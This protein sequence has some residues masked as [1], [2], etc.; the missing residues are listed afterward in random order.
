[1]NF[2]V[3]LMPYYA[4]TY[5]QVIKCLGGGKVLLLKSPFGRVKNLIFRTRIVNH[6]MGPTASQFRWMTW[7]GRTTT[8]W[9]ST[10]WRDVLRREAGFERQTYRSTSAT[11]AGDHSRAQDPWPYITGHHT[12]SDYGA[13]SRSSNSDKCATS[14]VIRIR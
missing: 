10:R 1:M 9:R 13:A 12:G 4:R 3:F 11:Y 5:V 8:D 7:S 2:H 6:V 14:T